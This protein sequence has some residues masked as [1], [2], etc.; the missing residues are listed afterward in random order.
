MNPLAE[1]RCIPCEGD[2]PKMTKAQAETLMEHVPEWKLSE[3][4]TKL[5]RTFSF[6]DFKSAIAFADAVGILAEE[7]WHHPDMTVS[8]GKVGVSFATHAV[9]GLTENDFVMAAKV[10]LLPR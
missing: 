5:S 9:R 3:D 1:K 8:W 6:N 4:A 2:V 10:D 7:E